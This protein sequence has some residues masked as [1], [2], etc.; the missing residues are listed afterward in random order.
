[1]RTLR[2]ACFAAAVSIPTVVSGQVSG[3]W[4]PSASEC[5]RA[6]DSLSAGAR[7]A[8]LWSFANNCGQAGASAVAIAIANAHSEAD[9]TYLGE[10]LPVATSFQH[11]GILNAALGLASDR[12]ATLAA[13]LFA[14]LVVGGEFGPLFDLPQAGGWLGLASSPRCD[15]FVSPQSYTS[16]FAMPAGYASGI[17]DSTEK[18]AG[19]ATDLAQVRALAGCLRTLLT[20][21]VPQKVPAALLQ[22]QYLCRK[23]FRVT[24]SATRIAR[25]S[26]T[27]DGWPDA[28]GIVVPA[29][30]AITFTAPVAGTVRLYQGASLIG[31]AENANAT[32]P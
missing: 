25:L 16:T 30:G 7:D 11:P 5:Q 9:T 17:A 18:L 19:D 15:A 23:E 24:S 6:A 12:N 2:A 4:S 27:V 26:I 8:S 20:A 28:I 10:L 29:N 21:Q 22:L 14:L 31:T 3:S 13:R 32:C 1:M